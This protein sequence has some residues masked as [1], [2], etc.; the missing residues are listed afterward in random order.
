MPWQTPF[1]STSSSFKAQQGCLYDYR[2]LTYG[3]FELTHISRDDH[4]VQLIK[5]ER[6]MAAKTKTK[7]YYSARNIATRVS[8]GK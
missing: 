6:A 8:F 3:S 7:D 4:T 5:F 1:A 2:R